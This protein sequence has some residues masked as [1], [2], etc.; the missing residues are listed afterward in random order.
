MKELQ[1]IITNG[2]N[3]TVEFKSSF[4]KECI[5]TIVAFSNTNGG[6]IFIGAS[7]PGKIPDLNE[8]DDEMLKDWSNTIKLATVPQIFP[9][10]SIK[11]FGDKKIVVIHVQEYPLKPVAYKGRYLKRVGA[12]NHLL[13]V[14]EIVELQIQSINSSFDA[15]HVKTE[16]N[17]LNQELIQSFFEEVKNTGRL[18][19]TDNHLVN[20][21]KLGLISKQKVTLAA[22]L[23]FG[24]H[25]TAIHIGRFKGKDHII[26][27][28]L[29]KAPLYVAVDNAMTF[30]KKNLRLEY[31]FTGE[32]KRQEIWQFPL[33]VLRELLLNSVIHKDYRNPT[34]VI[35]KIFDNR[36]EFTNPGSFMGNLKAE[37]LYKD[38][39]KA[40]HRNKLL[41]ETF[42][43]TGDVEK[44]GT[45]FIRIRK[46]LEE[47]PG[48]TY[49][50]SSDDYFI[51]VI[52]AK[53]EVLQDAMQDAMQDTMQDTM[54]VNA[55]IMTMK[56]VLT[57][58][59]IQSKLQLANRDYFR[60]E[61]L[62][63]AL[64][65]GLIEM[66]IPRKPTSRNQK[67][68]LTTKGKERQQKLNE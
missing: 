55:L 65:S 5:E 54:Q 25:N 44:Y 20:L 61:Y 33:P 45:G 12:S 38:D 1:Q 22:N 14:E 23:L 42:Y 35:I 67:Y 57:R 59:E 60:K 50:I 28:M 21:E 15:V 58:E 62:K 18:E 37:D 48:V 6:K 41:A 66:T 17:D 2:E 46:H 11:D 68:R 19:L 56:G 24:Q 30:I 40:F 27:D 36:I 29:I 8:I 16:I 7:P 43:L 31:K 3:L 32:L 64:D 52:L 9:Q 51:Q 63:P 53:R 39:Y 26:D 49:S 10:I 47:Y 34:D 4:G 13:S